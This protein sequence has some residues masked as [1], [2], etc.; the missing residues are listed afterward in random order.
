MAGGEA[1]LVLETCFGWTISSM[2]LLCRFWG[3]NLQNDGMGFL[4]QFRGSGRA[5]GGEALT[6]ASRAY[7]GC[8]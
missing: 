2:F 1:A 7:Q 4:L 5:G 6:S 3:N 8:I